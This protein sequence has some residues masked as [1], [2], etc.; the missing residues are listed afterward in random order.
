MNIEDDN[1]ALIKFGFD[2]AVGNFA[3]KE[4]SD[5][6][7]RIPGKQIPTHIPSM[8]FKPYIEGGG[9]VVVS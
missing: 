5:R 2:L 9:I 6:T 8:L 1:L 7:D 4:H 3:F